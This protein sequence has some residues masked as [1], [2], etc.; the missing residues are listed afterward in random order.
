VPLKKISF[1]IV[2]KKRK[3]IFASPLKNA[4]GGKQ[5]KFIKKTVA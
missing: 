3:Y 2:E 4:S 1:Y 5:R